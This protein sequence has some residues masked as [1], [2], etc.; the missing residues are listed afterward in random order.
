M[1]R[2][3][4]EQ[5]AALQQLKDELNMPRRPFTL[6]PTSIPSLQGNPSWTP[7]KRGWLVTLFIVLAAFVLSIVASFVAI[8]LN[9]ATVEFYTPWWEI[10]VPTGAGILMFIIVVLFGLFTNAKK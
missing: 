4:Q 9:L 6:I 7:R 10:P 1:K 3:Q 8:A 2:F 5:A